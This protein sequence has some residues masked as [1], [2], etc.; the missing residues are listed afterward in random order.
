MSRFTGRVTELR[1]RLAAVPD[2]NVLRSYSQE[3][4]DRVLA[5]LFDGQRGGTYVDVGAHDPSRFSNTRLL[6]EAGWS[7]LNIDPRPGTEQAFAR[8]RRRDT[9][10][11]CG[12]AQESRSGIFWQFEE[13]ALS[14]FDPALAQQRQAEGWRLVDTRTVQLLPLGPL[15]R[16]HLGAG[17]VDLLNID[18]EGLDLEVLHSAELDAITYRVLCLEELSDEVLGTGPAHRFVTSKGYRL[19]AVT[20]RSRIYRLT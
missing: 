6:Y 8:A 9:T 13:S 16:Q 4:E 2:R 10:L 1:R 5:S 17:P 3:G 11:E 12:I 7:G 20:G 15:V 14:T 19:V 18:V